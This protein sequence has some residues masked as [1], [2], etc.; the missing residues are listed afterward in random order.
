MSAGKLVGR[1]IL[2]CYSVA[3]KTL[4]L[5]RIRN[6][7]P[8]FRPNLLATEGW[9]RVIKLLYFSCDTLV[10]S[11][12]LAKADDEVVH[13]PEDDPRATEPGPHGSAGGAGNNKTKLAPKIL[14]LSLKTNSYQK[15][16]R[17]QSNLTRLC[18]QRTRRKYDGFF[19]V[20]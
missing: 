4:V 5:Y 8:I 12:T 9:K 15:M 1:N 18:M 14:K 19:T 20:R 11:P 6:P 17:S 13:G 10:P 2:Y 7:D 3:G 16:C